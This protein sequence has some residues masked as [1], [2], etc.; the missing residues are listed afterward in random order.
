MTTGH[1]IYAYLNLQMAIKNPSLDQVWLAGFECCNEQCDE[2]ANPYPTG[3][4][5]HEYW[6]EGWFS[7]YL[8]EEPLL[9]P[10]EWNDPE[11]DPMLESQNSWQN[12]VWFA[13]ELALV[14]FAGLALYAAY[15]FVV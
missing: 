2:E 6:R 13:A 11:N 7:A 3:S 5:E 12:K 15:D 4:K 1:E 10:A 14:L 8:A 9:D